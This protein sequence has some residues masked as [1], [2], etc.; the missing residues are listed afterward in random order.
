MRQ[1]LAYYFREGDQSTALY[2]LADRFVKSLKG[3]IADPSE[4]NEDYYNRELREETV[5]FV[6]NENIK[7]QI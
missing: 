7:I 3:R 2:S 6:V 5:D 4:E 1:E